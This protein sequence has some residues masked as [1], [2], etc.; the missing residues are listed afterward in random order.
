MAVGQRQR[1]YSG[2]RMLTGNYLNS[3]PRALRFPG[4]QLES[5][6]LTCLRF[7]GREDIIRRE[8]QPQRGGREDVSTQEAF[9]FFYRVL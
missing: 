9:L 2:I 5:S 3:T 7:G 8:L 1:L 6:S 4:V